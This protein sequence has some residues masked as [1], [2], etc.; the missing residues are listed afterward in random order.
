LSA[1]NGLPWREHGYGDDNL[2]TIRTR[3]G[4]LPAKFL[5]LRQAL[6]EQSSTVFEVLGV[7]APALVSTSI[8]I[9]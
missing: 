9:G 4:K 5:H 7:V 1:A 2:I 6:C 8:I 3:S